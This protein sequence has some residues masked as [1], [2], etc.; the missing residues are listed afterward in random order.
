MT[1]RGWLPRERALTLVLIA[2]TA[3]AVY[4]CFRL[5]APFFPALTWALALAVVTSPLYERIA[6]RVKRPNLT[7]GLAVTSV[8]V[9]LAAPGVFMAQRLVSQASGVV[10]AV[11]T[12]TESGQWRTMAE[13]NPQ[14]AR[15]LGWI[16]PHV[17]VRG[18]A[19]QAANAA[20]SWLSSFVGGSLW[21]V[22]QLLITFFTLFYLFRDRHL[23]LRKVKSL[24]PLSE[25]ET[26]TLFA[27]VSDT[28]Y[29]T[30]YGSFVVSLSQGVLG[31]LMFWWLG[32]PAP[33]FWGSVMTLLA[34]IPVLGAPVVW[35]P[36]AIFLA[37]TGN[38]GRALILTAWG[39]VVVGSIDNLL[40]PIL[41]GDKLRMHTL[42][43]FFAVLGG[44]ALFGASGL[45]LGPV[46]VTITS[47]LIEVWQRRTSGGRPVEDLGGG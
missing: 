3:L 16:E 17:D 42:V 23:M 41:V 21:M 10:Q 11:K 18:V 27:R 33:L 8:A 20:A 26:D 25:A 44:L 5:A 34:L 45:I 24:V 31:G 2:A 38:E 36:A 40:Y 12:H 1:N 28:T 39:V 19:E 4:V 9:I 30:I 22:V 32:L 13:S 15:A 43:V 6:E 14:V 29:A 35:I 47:L 37:L 46:A 7:A